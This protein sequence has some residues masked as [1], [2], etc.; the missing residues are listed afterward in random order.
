M[1]QLQLTFG[2]EAPHFPSETPGFTLN[3]QIETHPVAHLWQNC[4]TTLLRRRLPLEKNFSLLGLPS[5]RR[6][7][8]VLIQDLI[9]H[10]ERLRKNPDFRELI[11]TPP[12]DRTLDQIYLNQMHHAFEKL[13]GQIENVSPAYKTATSLQRH[14]IRQLNH[15]VHE[16]EAQLASPNGE[17]LFLINAFLDAPRIPLSGINATDTQL[18]FT[19]EV[20]Q[21][22]VLL[23]YAQLGKTP[24]EAYRDQDKLIENQNISELRDL[25]GEFDIHLSKSYRLRDTLSGSVEDYLKK[26]AHPIPAQIGK[27]RVAHWSGENQILPQDLP[28]HLQDFPHVVRIELREGSQ[29]LAGCQYPYDRKEAQNLTRDYYSDNVLIRLKTRA[30]IFLQG[31]GG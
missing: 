6:T 3:F 23:H 11:P 22:D 25:T 24:I 30:E 31:G 17:R 16:I 29:L 15:L 2:P 14:S 18:S 8:D 26:R 1:A 28:K 21:G 13:I 9:A 19:N 20:R 27:Y 4:L 12:A 7:I 5:Q 10:A